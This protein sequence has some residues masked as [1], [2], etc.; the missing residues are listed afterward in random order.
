MRPLGGSSWRGSHSGTCRL[1]PPQPYGRESMWHRIRLSIPA[2]SHERM[3]WHS[4]NK[5]FSLDSLSWEW[6]WNQGPPNLSRS[7][8]W[9]PSS[10]C[11]NFLGSGVCVG[12]GRE[13]R[14]PAAH[15]NHLG[16]SKEW[17]P[18]LGSPTH[19]GSLRSRSALHKCST[20]IL[21]QLA[22]D[23]E[24]GNKELE[25]R[26]QG[27]CSRSAIPGCLTWYKAFI[28]SPWGSHLIQIEKVN[29]IDV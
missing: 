18:P 5:A 29:L 12:E 1:D 27:F 7:A 17:Q 14:L 23:L 21:A 28:Y 11:P 24:L 16:V 2:P 15:Q 22:S 8:R 19:L 25:V 26:V 13:S 6:R 9:T 4:W 10:G 3:L 20:S